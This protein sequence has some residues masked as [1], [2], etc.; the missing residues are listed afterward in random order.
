MKELSNEGHVALI[1]TLM[2]VLYIVLCL[3]TWALRTTEYSMLSPRGVS[4]ICIVATTF[5]TTVVCVMVTWSLVGPFRGVPQY[6]FDTIYSPDLQSDGYVSSVYFNVNPRYSMEMVFKV[7]FASMLLF[8][9]VLWLVKVAFVVIYFEFSKDL[10]R[11]TRNLLYVTIAAIA[12]SFTFVLCLYTLWCLPISGNWNFDE[13]IEGQSCRASITPS[14]IISV[15][16]VITD[17]LSML[18]PT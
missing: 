16:N 14:V 13:L 11:R 1:W 17:V 7:N 5:L 2:S 15:I 12:V 10:S 3:R 18:S 6:V 8:Y 9:I 4:T